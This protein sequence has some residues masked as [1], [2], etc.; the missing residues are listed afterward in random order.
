MT[1]LKPQPCL[2]L[3]SSFDTAGGAAVALA[4]TLDE[5]NR[6]ADKVKFG[7]K[8]VFQEALVAKMQRSFLIGEKQKRGRRDFRLGDVVNAH[9]ASLRSGAA[10]QVDFFLEP[11]VQCRRDDAAA[12]RFPTLIDERKKLV[13]ALT[14]FRGEK[15][16]WRVTQ[17]FQFRADHFFVVK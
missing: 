17:E 15:H 14:S 13:R 1:L 4:Q 8:L 6:S 9:R 16:N 7:A 3:S 12:A 5:A 10:L 2:S 11:I